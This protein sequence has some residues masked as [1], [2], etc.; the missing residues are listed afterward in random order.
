MIRIRQIK[1]N[2]DSN[3]LKDK[4][5]SRL[6]IKNDELID[7]KINKRS[8][9]ARLK[10]KLYYIYEVDVTLKNEDIILKNNKD[11]DI[12]KTS[13]DNYNFEPNNK[14]TKKNIVVVGMGPAGLFTSY[15]LLKYGY[16]VIIIERGEKVEDRVKTV[17]KLFSTGILNTES[18]VQFGEGG[19]GTFSDGKLNTLIK[20]KEGRIKLVLETF[21][22]FG[23]PKEIL[24]DSK[25]HIGTDILRDV[26]INM[27]NEIIKMGGIINYNT[28]LTDVVLKDN[29]VCSIVVDDKD[30]IKCDTLVL[31]L[32]HSA[33]DTFKMLYKRGIIMESK[34][35]AVGIR[36]MHNQSMINKSQYGRDDLT[37]PYKLTYKA[38]NNRGVYTFCM[39]PGGYVVN[40]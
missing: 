17:E 39:C 8:I 32:G 13:I 30:E 27:R 24:Y 7:F 34:T 2:L 22:K 18:N 40:A 33:R 19:A 16:K 21:V 28:K 4:I 1:V 15:M 25:P 29:K 10:P 26:I 31:A 14:N 23:A 11:K 12:L 3:N 6:K 38:S 35:F 36:I 9:D 5:L 37:A 20:D